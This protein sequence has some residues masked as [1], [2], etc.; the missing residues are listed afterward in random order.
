MAISQIFCV[1]RADF[2]VSYYYFKF[3]INEKLWDLM[4][5]CNLNLIK[6]F[7]I[8]NQKLIEFYIKLNFR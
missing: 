2:R 3:N 5:N 6:N 4:E 8:D 7:K 1:I